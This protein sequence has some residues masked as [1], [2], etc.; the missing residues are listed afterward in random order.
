MLL[1][2][3]AEAGAD[4]DSIRIYGFEHYGERAADA[5]LAELVR[6]F[7]RI[8]QWPFAARLRTD[9]E[10]SVRLVPFGGHN[11][12]YDLGGDVVEIVRVLHHSVDWQNEL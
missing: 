5:Y 2:V 4:L 7:D 11:I 3:S 10:P 8:A 9:I 6:S 12:F 1:R